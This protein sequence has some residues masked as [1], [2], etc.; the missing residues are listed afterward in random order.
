[1]PSA[2]TEAIL[3]PCFALLPILHEHVGSWD[4]IGLALGNVDR[5]VR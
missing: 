5:D 4:L 2:A 1:M 3:C